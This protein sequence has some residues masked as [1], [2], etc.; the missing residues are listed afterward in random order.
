MPEPI[1]ELSNDSAPVA[2][3]AVETP[4]PIDNVETLVDTTVET[5]EAAVEVPATEPTLYETPDGRKV[6]ADVLQKEWKDNFLPEFTRKSQEL[7]EIK[8]NT[9]ELNK[10]KDN[11]PAWKDPEYQPETYAEVIEIAKQ[12]AL[13]ELEQK[14]FKEQEH[15]RTIQAQVENDIA[16]LRKIDPNLDENLLFAHATKYG[17]N[18]VK[19]AYNNMSDMNKTRLEAE[20]RTLKNIKTREVVPVAVPSAKIVDNPSEYDSSII[21]SFSSAS[22][23]YES[24]KNK[25]K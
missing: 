25:Q 6:T 18:N 5:P 16:D 24:L 22:D 3:A 15:V 19:T 2:E 12:E 23:Y 13:R 9:G 14:N 21:K 10:P 1:F 11:V 7:A 20:Q 8:R 4:S 17:F